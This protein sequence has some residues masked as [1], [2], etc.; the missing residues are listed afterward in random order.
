MTVEWTEAYS[1]YPASSWTLTYT[2]VGPAKYSL[3]ATADG[4]SHK[5]SVPKA[6]TAAYVPGIYRMIGTITDGTSQYQT[7]VSTLEILEDLTA[8]EAG[9]DAISDARKTLASIK[10]AIKT[11]AEN[12]YQSLTIA[13]RTKANWSFEELIKWR[14]LYEEEVAREEKAERLESGISPGSRIFVRFGNPS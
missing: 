9:Y 13:G 2:L 12:P 14:K 3:T 6:T 4:E 7:Y 11:Y 10:E 8:E 5:V 1:D